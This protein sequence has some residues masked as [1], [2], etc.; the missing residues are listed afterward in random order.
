MTVESTLTG[1]Y[2]SL[3]AEATA[4]REAGGGSIVNMSSMA[5]THV[6]RWQSTYGAAKAGVDM[7][8]RVAAGE[9]GPHGVGVNAVLS[10]QC[11]RT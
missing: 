1:T 4:I 3:Q 9:L 6:S 7:L 5:A 8:T 11:L 2:R 10:V